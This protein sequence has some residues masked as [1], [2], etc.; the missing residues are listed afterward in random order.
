MELEL[1]L[2]KDVDEVDLDKTTKKPTE[3]Y[4]DED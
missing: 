1:D 4:E 2:G 3:E